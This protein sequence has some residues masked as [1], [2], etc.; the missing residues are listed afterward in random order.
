MAGKNPSLERSGGVL[1]A[2]SAIQDLFQSK[3]R[4][5]GASIENKGVDVKQ[6]IDKQI[7][8]LLILRGFKEIDFEARDLISQDLKDVGFSDGLAASVATQI[9]MSTIDLDP[10]I[11][12]TVVK[13]FSEVTKNTFREFHA[14]SSFSRSFLPAP[15]PNDAVVRF[16]KAAGARESEVTRHKL[17]EMREANLPKAAPE[18]WARR[19]GRT[20]SAIDFL[21]RVW[22]KYME[23][24]ILFQ[25]DIKRLGDAKLVQAVRDRCI[26]EGI[27]ASTVLP[28][29]GSERWERIAGHLSDEEIEAAYRL[30]LKRYMRNKRA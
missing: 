30:G 2:L 4:K 26:S 10:N 7:R 21:H 16:L 19:V 6:L 11:R 14:E 24:G 20:E 18:T 25:D 8:D 9:V 29:P 15:E 23:M 22:G 28:P 1:S 5:I 12:G 27:D 3:P 17:S 13:A